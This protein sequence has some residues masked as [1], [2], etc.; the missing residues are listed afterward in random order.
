MKIVYYL[1]GSILSF[2]LQTTLCELISINGVKPD[3][4]LLFLVYIALVEKRTTATIAGFLLGL[5]EDFSA[6]ALCGLAALTNTIAAFVAGSIK[7]HKEY[8]H[9]YEPIIVVAAASFIR[10]VLAY[11][12]LS[13]GSPL[14]FW[15]SILLLA[16]P[17]TL[18]TIVIG[19]IVLALLPR[20][21]WQRFQSK[22]PIE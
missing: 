19:F 21:L 2:L 7:G 15:R 18:Y 3:I 13:L 16:L 9:F 17:S 8:Y 14:G 12:L 6:S 11:S 10:N 1:I 20:P 5:M 22:Y 4:I